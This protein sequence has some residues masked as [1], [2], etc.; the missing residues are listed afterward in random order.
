M[1]KGYLFSISDAVQA[2]WCASDAHRCAS[3][4]IGAWP[5][6]VATLLL[7]WWQIMRHMIMSKDY[8]IQ[9]QRQK[10]I[11]T[12]KDKRHK[13]R[14]ATLFLNWW[15]MMRHMIM[16]TDNCIQIQRHKSISTAKDKC[17]RKRVTT[18]LWIWL[19]V[20]VLPKI[21]ATRKGWQHCYGSC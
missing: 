7:N 12:A 10:I 5:T 16:S 15:Q 14:V 13:K 17:N 1:S 2:H 6:L 4:K 18:L 8:C 20:P 21:S 19:K 11:G 9:I 3:A